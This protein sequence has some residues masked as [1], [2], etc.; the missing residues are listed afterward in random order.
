MTTSRDKRIAFSLA[1]VDLIL[2]GFGHF[3]KQ[4]VSGYFKLKVSLNVIKPAFKF[5]TWITRISVRLE[6]ASSKAKFLL[7]EL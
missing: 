1:A 7:L 4:N 3:N 6:M 2:Q 5:S